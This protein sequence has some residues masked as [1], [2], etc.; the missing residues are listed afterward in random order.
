[1]EKPGAK[2]YGECRE[3]SIQNFIY[4]PESTLEA[5]TLRALLAEN[6]IPSTLENDPPP[7]WQETSPRPPMWIGV[8]DGHVERATRVIQTYF[9]QE[10]ARPVTEERRQLE[11]QDLRRTK[12][13][14]LGYGS[15]LSVLGIIAGAIEFSPPIMIGSFIL[16]VALTIQFVRVARNHNPP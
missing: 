10:N 1:V 6:D 13:L 11:W 12:L 5:D 16:G 8:S 15:G 7:Q 14:Y 4:A 3:E 2:E 9:D